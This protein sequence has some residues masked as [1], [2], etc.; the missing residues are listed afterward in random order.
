MRIQSL[1]IDGYGV[2]AGLRIDAFG[3]GVH[4]VLGPN[5]AGKTTLLGFLR[6]MLYGSASADAGYLPPLRGRRAGGRLVIL[7]HDGPCV[8]H[9]YWESV[10]PIA[11]E[12]SPGDPGRSPNPAARAAAVSPSFGAPEGGTNGQSAAVPREMIT[13]LDARGEAI[14]GA[15][16]LAWCGGVDRATF[17]N[18]FAFGLEQLERLS[19][20]DSTEAATLL[21]GLSLGVDRVSLVEAIGQLRAS[22][23]GLVDPRGNGCRV[24]TLAA[25]YA[26]ARRRARRGERSA[27]RYARLL[28]ER[29]ALDVEIEEL[30]ARRE[31]LE[32]QARLVELSGALAESWRRRAVIEAELSALGS[33]PPVPDGLIQRLE[34]LDEQCRRDQAEAASLAA[35]Y[36]AAARQAA[37]VELNRAVWNQAGRIE[38]LQQQRSWIESVERAIAELQREI[39]AM[40]TDRNARLAALGLGAETAAAAPS[41]QKL[42][43]LREPLSALRAAARRRA[44]LAARIEQQRRAAASLAEQFDTARK[45]RGIG[46][47]ASAI[48]IAGA[49]VAQ[50]R[51][52]LQLDERLTRMQRD[53]Q[54][55][56]EQRDRL[57]DRQWTP[58]G[59]LAGLGAV[60]VV[61]VALLLTGLLMPA[62]V[63]GSMGWAMALVGLGGTA[64]AAAGKV[65]YQ[66]L[67]ARQLAACDEQLRLLGPRIEQT[68]RERQALD[69]R[70]PRGGGPIG[71]RLSAAER[72]LAEL[73][74]LA[75]LD[76]RRAAAEQELAS[77][78]RRLA[79]LDEQLAEA[80]RRWRQALEDAG[81]PPSLRPR[82][83]RSILRQGEPWWES[84]RRL[85]LRREELEQRRRE[86]AHWVEQAA[87]VAA[88]AALP[89]IEGGVQRTIDVL[90]SALAEA[91]AVA[92]RRKALADRARQARREYRARRRMLRE[93]RAELRRMAGEQGVDS[94]E[95]LRRRAATAARAA[96]L[97]AQRDALSRE[98]ASA[99]GGFASEEEIA[100]L[101]AEPAQLAAR[102]REAE[103]QLSGI[104]DRL[105]QMHERRGRLGEQIDALATDAEPSLAR[106]E[107]GLLR[108][109]LIE[110]VER[111]HV[112]ALAA[113]AL[114]DVCAVWQRDRQPEALR[115]AS[116]YFA[117][118]TDGRYRR[119]WTPLEVESLRVDD[120]EGRTL[121]V[122]SLSR[123][124][125]E[126]L[127]ISLRL[128]LVASYAR[129]GV[130]LPL[131]LDDALVNFDAGRAKLAAGLL[132]DFAAAIPSQVLVFTCHDHIAKL[133]KALKCPVVVLPDHAQPDPE[134][135]SFGSSAPPRRPRAARAARPRPAEKQPVSPPAP[136][137]VAPRPATAPAPEPADVPPTASA[138]A[139]AADSPRFVPL[140]APPVTEE[141]PPPRVVAAAQTWRA[142]HLRIESR[143]DLPRRP[144]AVFDADFFD[145]GGEATAEQ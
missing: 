76:A 131:V 110:A 143:H 117:R 69:A 4:V 104:D 83:L 100:A 34:Q 27:A 129:R 77:E 102:R 26:A 113:A 21:Y 90:V 135:L 57:A 47:L 73:E 17:E 106:F 3:D 88:D 75:A 22:R 134:P 25:R 95:A 111:W 138:T 23:D 89:P 51:R 109:R 122:E 81:L 56:R 71:V 28:A 14:E 116:E 38:M 114:D 9:R 52:R 128:A 44:E 78:T 31:R 94:L 96:E 5:E 115:E 108:R 137:G 61:G 112:L 70:L 118:L 80:R 103:E 139:P 86:L 54:S 35:E 48:E 43:A 60:F 36:R 97:A 105:R 33:P 91:Q 8:I 66:R 16:V 58:W 41:R 121:G 18:V 37:A 63:T 67:V 145:S 6:W 45:A 65:A 10:A 123:G 127:F 11:A 62:S 40:E 42:R 87:R 24:G 19:T 13:L 50:L 46:E 107:M 140:A 20:L 68:R 132:R 82:Q 141:E 72:A 53:E 101:L 55:L 74:E 119:V 64:A 1:E 142:E 92:A 136:E 12:A 124:T 59:V 120:A 85:T 130:R 32:R 49:E 29:S 15:D 2:W 133:F 125:R 98:I 84:G 93:H 7:G 126:Q 144:R 99:V 30:R 39:A 79:P